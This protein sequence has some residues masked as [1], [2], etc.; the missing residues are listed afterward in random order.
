M[1]LSEFLSKACGFFRTPS[2]DKFAEPGVRISTF[3]QDI[4]TSRQLSVSSFMAFVQSWS[5]WMR[6]VP[7]RLAPISSVINLP[8][9]A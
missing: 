2:N 9:G 8:L 4:Q 3:R 6:Q 1:M 7:V 5:F